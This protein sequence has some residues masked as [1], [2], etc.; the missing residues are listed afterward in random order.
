MGVTTT[1][2][3]GAGPCTAG[4][5]SATTVSA[6][7]TC[8]QSGASTIAYYQTTCQ[9]TLPIG[10]NTLTTIYAGGSIS[11]P[12]IG[13]ACCQNTVVTTG[14]SSLSCVN[15]GLG[16]QIKTWCSGTA[17]QFI[18]NPNSIVATSQL[19]DNSLCQKIPSGAPFNTG[20]NLLATIYTYGNCLVQ[21][22]G[23][24]SSNNICSGNKVTNQVFTGTTCSGTPTFTSPAGNGTCTSVGIGYAQVV[25]CG[26]QSNAFKLSFNMIIFVSFLLNFL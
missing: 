20:N 4:Q 24:Q 12:C 6:S 5:E 23:L 13:A 25:A 9:G 22:G 17:S 19:W 16:G 8:Y 10:G 3:I 2:Y 14:N 15:S 18:T 21:P 11:N 26:Y 7:N 1:I